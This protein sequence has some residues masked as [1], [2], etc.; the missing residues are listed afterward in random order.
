MTCS[1]FQPRYITSLKG[2]YGWLSSCHSRSFQ[3]RI[4]AL[5][6]QILSRS[7]RQTLPHGA[8]NN[9]RTK[10]V[11]GWRNENNNRSSAKKKSQLVTCLLVTGESN[12]YSLSKLGFRKG[13]AS[14][15]MCPSTFS[16]HGEMAAQQKVRR[17]PKEGTGA[18]TRSE[19]HRC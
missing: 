13:Q 11:G 7:M 10:D 19:F 5:M 14:G 6:C 16:F 2:I 8:Q 9:R 17:L 15:C 4:C 12:S 18:Q 3:N 1:K